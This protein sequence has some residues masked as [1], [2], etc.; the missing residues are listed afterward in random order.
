MIDVRRLRVLHAVSAYGSV[1]AAAAALGYSAP[2]VSQQL[3]ALEREVDMRL[4]ERAGRGLELTPAAHILVG[5]TDALLA[6]LEAAEADLAALRDQ[7]A[8]RVALAAFPSAAANLVPAAWAALTASAPQV[9]LDLTEMEPEE[10]LPAVLRGETDVAVA[11][12]YDLLPRPLD[13]LFERREL[14]RDPV[15]LAVPETHP[16]A[17]DGGSVGLAADGGSV[18]LAADGGP[19]PLAALSGQPFLAPREATSCAEMIQRACA[20]AGFVPRVVARATDFQVLLSLV[21]A[22][23]GVTLVPGLAARRLPPGVRLVPPAEPVTRRVFTVSRRGGDRKP[24]VRVV[25]DALTD[26]A[27]WPGGEPLAA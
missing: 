3:A 19:V 17:A 2:A 10:S 1:T 7:V 13:P 18:G 23:A 8:G 27:A 11:H 15:L 12:E 24:A 21:A 4:T 16:L 22:G 5:H 9:R 26:A 20:R 25:L 6:R 14:L